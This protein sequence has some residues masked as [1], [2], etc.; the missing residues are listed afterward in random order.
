M[1][2]LFGL[3]AAGL[4]LFSLFPQ[5][6]FIACLTIC[7]SSSLLTTSSITSSHLNP[8]S[9]HLHNQ[10][11]SSITSSHLNL[12]SHYITKPPHHISTSLPSTKPNHLINHFITSQP[13]FYLH[14]QTTS[15]ITITSQPL[16]YP[17]T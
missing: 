13:I 9:I 17:S 14:N 8:S 12:S 10:T 1:Y 15:S 6:S 4:L 7:S 3:P 5:H 2:S 16:F 11:I